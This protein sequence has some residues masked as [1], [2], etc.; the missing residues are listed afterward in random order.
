MIRIVASKDKKVLYGELLSLAPTDLQ[1]GLLGLVVLA[2]EA[3]CIEQI[4]DLLVV[5]LEERDVDVDSSCA[6]SGFGL[7]KDFIDGSDGQ[8]DVANVSTHL[9]FASSFISLAL[10]SLVALHCVRLARTCLSVGEDR[11]MEA[12]DHFGDQAFDLQLV[13]DV[14]LTVLGV[15]DFVEFEILNGIGSSSFIL[16]ALALVDPIWYQKCKVRTDLIPLT[17]AMRFVSVLIVRRLYLWPFSSSCCRSGLTRIAT[18]TF[19]GILFYI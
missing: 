12:L 3:L 8:T 7:L 4:I 2:F 15:D 10:L 14:F 13:E 17:Y 1:P 19:A 9:D 18:R 6:P 16:F 5:N 11:R